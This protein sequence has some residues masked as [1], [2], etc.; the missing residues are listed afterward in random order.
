MNLFL[1]QKVS[2]LQNKGKDHWVPLFD[3]HNLTMAFENHNHIFK[4]SKK[5]KHFSENSKGTLY[6]GEGSW[7]VKSKSDHQYD[8]RFIEKAWNTQCVWIISIN[9]SNTIKYEA[10]DQNNSILDSF[11]SDIS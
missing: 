9:G 3:Y 8:D 2:L 1:I 7:G 10:R 5:I 11:E 6:L 4:R